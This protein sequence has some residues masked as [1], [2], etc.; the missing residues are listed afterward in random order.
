M[1]SKYDFIR[2]SNQGDIKGLSQIWNQCLM[3]PCVWLVTQILYPAS[4]PLEFSSFISFPRWIFIDLARN[5]LV[6]HQTW[7]LQSFA[8]DRHCS[9]WIDLSSTVDEGWE[10]GN[11]GSQRLW[12]SSPSGTG[13]PGRL[14]TKGLPSSLK[15]EGASDFEKIDSR[16]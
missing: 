4:W 14:G 5:I 7:R 11:G 10:E 9:P 12:A 6:F 3:F 15:W 13:F 2:T 1:T 16:P 8:M